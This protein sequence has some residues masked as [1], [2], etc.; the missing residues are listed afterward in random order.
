MQDNCDAAWWRLFGC[1][2]FAG[3]VTL[4]VF[5]AWPS[6]DL[7]AAALFHHRGHFDLWRTD[8]L[9]LRDLYMLVFAGLCVIAGLGAAGAMLY[10]GRTVRL[11]LWLYAVLVPVIG[12]GLLANL[13]FKEHWGR[14]RPVQLEMFG[15]DKSFSLPFQFGD[16]CSANCSFVS[17]EGA[18]AAAIA[19]VLIGLFGHRFAGK[20]G[21]TMLWSGAGLWLL[22]GAMIRMVPGK[23]FLSDSL[24]AFIITGMVGLLLYRWLDIGRLRRE[25]TFGAYLSAALV[26]PRRIIPGWHSDTA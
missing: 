26:L 3:L 15:G 14:A 9:I 21:H 24:F 5:V 2:S 8:M 19:V 7:K 12:P 22:G 4:A 20:S 25:V 18:S 1:L 10:P 6:I 17:G 23:H 13:V 16:Q 11:R